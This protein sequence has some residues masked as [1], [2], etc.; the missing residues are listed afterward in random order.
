MGIFAVI[1]FCMLFGFLLM[2]FWC[3]LFVFSTVGGWAA[4]GAREMFVK[5]IGH[6]LGMKPKYAAE[7]QA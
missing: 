2:A 1:G 5:K 3:L 4:Q 6:K 7:E